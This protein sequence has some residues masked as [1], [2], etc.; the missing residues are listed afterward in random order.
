[1]DEYKI[2]TLVIN[3]SELVYFDR[4]FEAEI[5]L[6]E[7]LDLPNSIAD[8]LKNHESIDYQSIIGPDNRILNEI[9]LFARKLS[10]EKEKNQVLLAIAT[11]LAVMGNLQ[12]AEE[13]GMEISE[14]ADRGKCFEVIFNDIL[15]GKGWKEALEIFAQIKNKESQNYFLKVLLTSLFS[16]EINKEFILRAQRFFQENIGAVEKLL[17][18]Y[19]LHELFFGQSAPENIQR[20]NRTLNIQWA[21]DTKNQLMSYN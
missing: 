11:K 2:Q 15:K 18:N 5:V 8:E 12:L 9:L 14:V 16:I 7:A 1:M 13:I 17:Q 6:N 3:I 19:A 20:F 10:P 4:F 21:I